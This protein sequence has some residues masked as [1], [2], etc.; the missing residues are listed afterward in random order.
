M[1]SVLHY[2]I[3]I[4][5]LNT[6]SV[7]WERR[8]WA[9][10]CRRA[11]SFNLPSTGHKTMAESSAGRRSFHQRADEPTPLGG[12]FGFIAR[13]VHVAQLATGELVAGAGTRNESAGQRPARIHSVDVGLR[14]GPSRCGRPAG[15]VGSIGSQRPRPVRQIGLGRGA[16]KRS[17]LSG[18]RAGNAQDLVRPTLNGRATASYFAQ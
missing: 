9:A 7:S 10:K 8:S 2:Y 18:R 1:G 14:S 16:S 6:E 3:I 11:I 15:P 17:S 13:P 4:T 12:G 5:S